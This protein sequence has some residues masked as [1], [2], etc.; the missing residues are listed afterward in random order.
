MNSDSRTRKFAHL[1]LWCII[2][3]LLIA[4]VN[5]V[6]FLWG[7]LT[8]LKPAREVAQYPPTMFGSEIS[9][10][11][12]ITVLKGTLGR[13]TLNSLF[14]SLIAI[15]LCALFSTIAAYA[16]TRYKF[17]ARK[18]IFLVILFGIPLSMGSAAM[19]VP[20]YMMF[21]KLHMTDKWYTL[22]LIY[23]AY[24]L[25]MAVWIM[26]GGMQSVPYAIEEAAM[27]DGASRSYIIFRLIPR[28]TLPTIACSALMTFIGAWN[29]YVVSSVMVNS[30][31]F[32][33][34]QVSIY[35]YIGFFGQE[36][37]PLTAAATVAVVPILLVF[38]F[39]G[40]FLVSGLTAGAVK[41]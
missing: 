15:V 39:L 30:S 1:R 9:F 35:N 29:E 12:Y 22:P 33:P 7:A 11:H 18:L 25:P 5:L 38:S 27:I 16:L 3:F 37:G 14:Y 31:D 41:E 26:I 6:P 23:T 17:R 28:L 32:Y 2:G 4:L 20:N 24:N 8:S 21:S 40:K 19:V 34:I 36:W 13:A 10:E